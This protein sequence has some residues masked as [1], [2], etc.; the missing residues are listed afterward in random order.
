MSGC[1]R[2]SGR[3]APPPVRR[4]GDSVRD[5]WEWLRSG[6]EVQATPGTPPFGLASGKEQQVLAAWDAGQETPWP[7]IL[8]RQL[9]KPW[10]ADTAGAELCD[11]KRAGG[12]AK[13]SVKPREWHKGV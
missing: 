4:F 3:A 8:P 12:P 7:Q 6:G 9:N 13:G 5:V 1:L 11:R 2:E 10:E